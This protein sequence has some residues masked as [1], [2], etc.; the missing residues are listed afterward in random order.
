M[1]SCNVSSTAADRCN[2]LFYFPLAVRHGLCDFIAR[3]AVSDYAADQYHRRVVVGALDVAQRCSVIGGP[4]LSALGIE[5]TEK[6]QK[7]T[8]NVCFS[9]I[10]F[11]HELEI[12]L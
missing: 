1:S 7:P 6:Q 9:I 2:F 3:Q 10:F 5:T 11:C 8:Q 4:C 12:S